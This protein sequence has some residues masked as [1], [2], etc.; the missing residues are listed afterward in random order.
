M[1]PFVPRAA[2]DPSPRHNNRGRDVG[3]ILAA[4]AGIVIFIFIL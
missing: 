3:I 1:A 4:L 2:S